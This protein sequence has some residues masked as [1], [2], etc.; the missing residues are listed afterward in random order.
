QG[1]R[2]IVG[3]EAGRFAVLVVGNQAVVLQVVVD[4]A[5]E[6]VATGLGDD[7][8]DQARAAGILG[9]NAAGEHLLLLDDLGVEVG[10]EGAGQ[11]VGDVDAVQEVDVVARAT[12]RAADV[13]VV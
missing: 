11:R 3:G 4:R 7:L 8:R 1:D 6:L 5:M 9:G 10:T 12:D 13:G 2:R